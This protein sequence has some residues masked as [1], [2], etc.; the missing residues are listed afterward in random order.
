MPRLNRL[1]NSPYVHGYY[2]DGQLTDAD[3]QIGTDWKTI[4]VGGLGAGGKGFFALDITNPDLSAET[5]NSGND[6]KILWEIDASA[7]SAGDDLG[8][9]YSRAAIGR[10]GDGKWYAAVGTGFNSVNGNGVLVWLD[11]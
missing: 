6:A 5:A 9:T 8:Y 10:L 4:L 1:A 3:V 11:V 2:V 7:S